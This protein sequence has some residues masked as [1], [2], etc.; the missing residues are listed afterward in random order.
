MKRI[1]SQKENYPL[2]SIV[3]LKKGGVICVIKDSIM[4][5][6]KKLLITVIAITSLLAI[7]ACRKFDFLKPSKAETEFTVEDAKE[8]FYGTFKKSASFKMDDKES[9][10]S[11]SKKVKANAP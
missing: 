1:Q 5:K 7:Q 6:N 9:I 3:Y 11:N 10:F 2:C 4:R 8:W